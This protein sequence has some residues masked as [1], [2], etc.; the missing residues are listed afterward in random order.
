MIAACRDVP[1]TRSRVLI[2]A[3][4]LPVSARWRGGR[5]QLTRS[6]GGLASGLEHLSKN[7]QVVWIGWPGDPGDIAPEEAAKVDALLASKSLRPVWLSAR[8]IQGF[9]EGFANGVLWPLFHYLPERVPVDTSDW[10]IYQQVNERYAEAVARVWRPGDRLWIHDYQLLLLPALVRARVPHAAIGFFLHIPFPAPDLFRTLLWRRPIVEGLLGADVIGFH[11][12]EYAKHFMTTVRMVLALETTA[13]HLWW[14]GRPVHVGAFPMGIDAGRFERLSR[15]P[16]VIARATAIRD[17]ARGRRLLVGVDRLDYTKGIPRRLLAFERLL[18]HEPSL[19]NQVRFIQVAVPSRVDVG[20]YRSFRRHIDELIGRINGAY[21]TTESV[22]IHYL[23]RSIPQKEL[24]A[25]YSAADVM[26]VT[27][28]RDGMN[29]VAK[30]FVASRVDDEGVLVLSEFA[31]AAS[32]LQ[33]ALLVNPY[34]IDHVARVMAS[35]LSLEKPE[36]TRRMRALRS[37]V[38]RFTVHNWSSEILHR[39]GDIARPHV[40]VP[41]ETPDDA[42]KA[43]AAG[44]L[45]AAGSIT[46][47]IDYDGT[48][49]PYA[50]TPED[51]VPDAELLRLLAALAHHPQIALHIVSGRSVDTLNRWFWRLK[52]DLWAEHSAAHRRS[53]T[54]AWERFV[55]GDQDWLERAT[56]YLAALTDE[57]PGA[58]LEEKSTGLAWHYRLV[59][60][61]RAARQIPRLRQE[62]PAVLQNAAV[63]IF[64]GHLVVEV[65]AR[66]ISKGLVVRHIVR[67][68]RQRGPVVAHGDDRTDVEIFAALPP[69][70]VAIRVGGGSTT[71]RYALADYRAVRRMLGLLLE[72]RESTDDETENPG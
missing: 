59:E 15:S 57:T 14:K 66:G 26:L 4:R 69:S 41:G 25:L 22:P 47:L 6:S 24:V 64:E 5:P 67:N 31:G 72:A 27:P 53:E 44:T 46:L 52:A 61:K 20:A 40:L 42:L 38:H 49:V 63:E 58:L 13:D 1:E 28:L 68:G 54:G 60:P 39:L 37:A 16:E 35:A 21:G 7:D 51:A 3:N 43:L 17:E 2:V 18:E 8:E 33:D 23:Y 29:L 62:L 12:Q 45:P 48:L 56:A 65:R 9:Y 32:E 10:G 55:A 30:E 19:R 50:E 11:T 71:A 70:G 36:R 34:D